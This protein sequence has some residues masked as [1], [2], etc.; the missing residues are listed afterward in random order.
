ML[1]FTTILVLLWVYSLDQT[2]GKKE[3]QVS[4]K[5]DLEPFTVLKASVVDGYKNISSDS[6][7]VVR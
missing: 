7:D 1:V 5:K 3:T 2:L 6:P 4:V